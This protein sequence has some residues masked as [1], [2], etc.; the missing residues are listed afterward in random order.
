MSNEN[1]YP[2]GRFAERAD[3]N[4]HYSHYDLLDHA[5]LYIAIDT[6]NLEICKIG[7]TSKIHPRMRVGE[8]KT[9]NPYLEL[10]ATYE[11]SA[12]TWGCSKKELHDIEGYIH[13]KR[14][15]GQALKYPSTLRD[16][17][18]FPTHPAEAEGQVDWILAKR[19]FSVQ[20]W[21]LFDTGMRPNLTEEQSIRINEVHFEALRE[22]KTIFRPYPDEYLCRA[23]DS[24][25]TENQI[26]G[27]LDYLDKFHAGDWV[28][29]I[30]LK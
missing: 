30:Y 5:W 18:W 8:G 28:T 1:H 26:E 13:N 21:T 29:K 3:Q 7:L 20:G 15:F 12:T 17:E 27:Y 16:S 19:G 24:G 23:L 4:D 9:Y 6:R 11:L 25:M 22:I 2:I 14:V 10:F